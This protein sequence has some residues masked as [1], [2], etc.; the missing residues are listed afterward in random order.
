MT[1]RASRNPNMHNHPPLPE[2][3]LRSGTYTP[4]SCEGS[5]KTVWSTPLAISRGAPAMWLTA[6]TRITRGLLGVI[7]LGTREKRLSCILLSF[8]CYLGL[9]RRQPIAIP[10]L[11]VRQVWHTRPVAVL[12]CKDLLSEGYTREKTPIAKG[13][14]IGHGRGAFNVA[15]IRS[16][17]G[18]QGEVSRQRV[19]IRGPDL[20]GFAC[21][22]CRT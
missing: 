16:S 11:S 5:G 19:I 14:Y 13:H 7:G 4:L 1:A 20:V 12:A 8:E 6:V 17:V 2:P 3:L 18:P 9:A 22:A 21:S 15:A 10:S